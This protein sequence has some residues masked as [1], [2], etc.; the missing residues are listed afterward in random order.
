MPTALDELLPHPDV[1]ERHERLVHAAPRAVEAA[2]REL[3][4]RDVPAV[5]L[6]AA[7][8]SLPRLVTGAGRAAA[9]RPLLDHALAA[10]FT[11][12]HEV[13][14]EEVVLGL[15]GRFWRPTG[16]VLRPRG[17]DW[18]LDFAEPGYA[19]GAMSITLTAEDGG[20]RVV[21]E[22]WV[23][24]TDAGARQAFARYWTVVSPFSGL[25]RRLLLR[26]VAARAEARPAE[27]A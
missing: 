18:F 21:T 24:S 6:L 3:T 20:T 25:I 1:T 26:A 14:G 7:V 8:R 12:L 16:G 10:G 13:P 27:R 2:F 19:K 23:R 5:A 17:R 15:V 9:D 4:L 11:V 22:T